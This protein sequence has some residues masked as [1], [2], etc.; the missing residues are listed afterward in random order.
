M[1]VA[2]NIR[3]NLNRHRVPG[4]TADLLTVM[5]AVITDLRHRGVRLLRGRTTTVRPTGI[6]AIIA[7]VITVPAIIVLIITGRAMIGPVI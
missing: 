7:R 6:R 5:E 1:S 3:K 2:V 4:I